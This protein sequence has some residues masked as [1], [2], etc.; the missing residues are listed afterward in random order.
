LEDHKKSP[1]SA[2]LHWTFCSCHVGANSASLRFRHGRS[3]A[4]VLF[5]FAIFGC[6][7]LHELVMR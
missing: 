6:V 5:V 4:A 2:S 7:V 1:E 3:R